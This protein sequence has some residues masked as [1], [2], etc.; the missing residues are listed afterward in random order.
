MLA[1]VLTVVLPL[2]LP[3]LI[4]GEESAETMTPEGVKLV[5]MAY[6]GDLAG[7]RAALE[8]G[9]DVHAQGVA[10]WTAL[11]GAAKGGHAEIVQHLLNQG[12]E[13]DS[14][15]EEYAATALMEAAV[16]NHTKVVKML[17]R[18]GA[19]HSHKTYHLSHDAL[20][21]AVRRGHTEVAD[22]LRKFAETGEVDPDDYPELHLSGTELVE[23]VLAG[24]VDP[25][26]EAVEKGRSDV[27]AV[28]EDEKWQ[29]WTPLIVASGKGQYDIA[30][31][32]LDAGADIDATDRFGSTALHAAAIVGKMRLVKLLLRRGADKSHKDTWGNT[33]HHYA[34]KW[35]HTRVA[36]LLSEEP[37]LPL[38]WR[39]KGV[40]KDPRDMWKDSPRDHEL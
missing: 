6:R 18:A 37:P 3:L 15:K 16:H 5:N 27:N 25:L 32:L 34:V 26:R 13:V 9:V 28:S 4:M 8:D 24:Q 35:H 12:A 17:L 33:A 10:G 36:P 14:I 19:E 22:I 39:H 11:H 38:Q 30:R 1:T 31:F 7:V 20:E 23:L 40:T 2:L 29:G 21:L